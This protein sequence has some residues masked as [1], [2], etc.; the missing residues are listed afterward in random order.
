MGVL[1]FI[2]GLDVTR[3]LSRVTVIC[4]S[5]NPPKSLV[6]PLVVYGPP[7]VV[8]S[9]TDVPFLAK[10]KLDWNGLENAPTVVEHWVQ[11]FRPGSCVR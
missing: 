11:V 10:V 7:F 8:E 5:D 6:E 4:E 1:K 9:T 2:K 3:A